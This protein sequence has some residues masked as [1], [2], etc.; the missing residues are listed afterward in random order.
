MTTRK[1]NASCNMS[2][3]KTD[4][5]NKTIIKA[6][7]KSFVW[8]GLTVRSKSHIA[9]HSTNPLTHKRGGGESRRLLKKFLKIPYFLTLI[10]NTH[11]PVISA[12]VVG[13]AG[14][15]FTLYAVSIGLRC[16]LSSKVKKLIF[17]LW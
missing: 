10:V 11:T 3:A 15:N 16:Y 5:T 7:A 12:S 14:A 4:F 1:R 2:C 13:R 9:T 6:L 8:L 17:T